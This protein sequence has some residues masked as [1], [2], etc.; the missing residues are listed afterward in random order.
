MFSDIPALRSRSPMDAGRVPRVP[1]GRCRR[2]TG[3]AAKTIAFRD[4]GERFGL[5]LQA[6]AHRLEKCFGAGT[7]LA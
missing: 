2:R 7:G 3:P 4:E 6:R 5:P 1:V